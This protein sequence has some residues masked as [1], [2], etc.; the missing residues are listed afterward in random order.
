[1]Q[2]IQQH[3]SLHCLNMSLLYKRD[4]DDSGRVAHDDVCFGKRRSYSKNW[5]ES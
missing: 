4:L 2:Q 3:V 1:V 5:L